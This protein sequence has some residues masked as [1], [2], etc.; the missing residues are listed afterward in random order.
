MKNTKSLQELH[1]ECGKIFKRELFEDTQSASRSFACEI[2][3]KMTENE[4]DCENCIG[5]NF[6]QLFQ[7]LNVE[8]FDNYKPIGADLD[9][10]M[11]TYIL[12][13]YLVYE[14][15]EFVFNEIDPDEKF[16][17][18]QDF[19]RSLKTMNEIRLWANF[20]KHPKHFFFVHWPKFIFVGQHFDKNNDTLLIN[21]SFLNNHY[22]SEKQDK[23]KCLENQCSVVVQFPRV[24]LLT[25]GFCNDFNAF[26]RFVCDNSMVTNFL[27]KK[28]NVFM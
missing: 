8:W 7:T 27:K 10:Y 22:S 17:L 1:I 11:T 6:N 14:R 23:P 18:T 26:I 28:S 13:L 20:L 3:D 21:T 19:R 5:E 16:H 4:G 2:W 15:I 12:W 25:T 9:F 24:D